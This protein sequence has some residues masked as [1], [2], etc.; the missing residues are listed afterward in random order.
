[1]AIDH[2]NDRNIEVSMAMAVEV[3]KTIVV[4]GAFACVV[5]DVLG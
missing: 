4:D 1:M 3:A 5:G 2:G